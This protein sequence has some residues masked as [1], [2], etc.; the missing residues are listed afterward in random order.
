[1]HAKMRLSLLIAA[2]V[3]I[4]MLTADTAQAQILFNR[5]PPP[6]HGGYYN[7]AWGMPVALVVPPNARRQTH[8]GWGVGNT[9][10]TRIR[11]QFERNYP[12]QGQYSRKGFKPTPRWPSDTNQY[13]T[14]YIRGPKRPTR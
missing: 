8:W 4:A 11:P 7:T 9:R 3:L 13:G 10:V 14:Y 2:A 5:T 12:G 6:W 1:M